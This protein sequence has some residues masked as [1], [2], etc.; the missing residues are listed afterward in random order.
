VMARLSSAITRKMIFMESVPGD[1]L[2]KERLGFLH[3]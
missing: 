1:R 2:D 3:F